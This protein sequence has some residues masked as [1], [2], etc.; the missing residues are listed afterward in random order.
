MSTVKL[1][2]EQKLQLVERIQ[3]YF[4]MELSQEMGQL[5]GENLLDFMIKELSPYLYNQAMADA[6]SVIGERMASIE[7]E[8]YALEKP[9]AR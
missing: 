1:P 3:Y 6:R 9:V 5:A 8:L 2:R 7:E 4:E